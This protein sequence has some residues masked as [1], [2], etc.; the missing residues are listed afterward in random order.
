MISL[1]MNTTISPT[2]ITNTTILL[3]FEIYARVVIA[4]IKFYNFLDILICIFIVLGILDCCKMDIMGFCIWIRSLVW[5]G[6]CPYLVNDWLLLMERYDFYGLKIGEI[7]RV[8]L[9]VRY[10][11]L[12]LLLFRFICSTCG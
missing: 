4:V 8:G 9:L 12:E 11:L 2:S 6:E 1:K 7:G 3:H 5:R 10:Y